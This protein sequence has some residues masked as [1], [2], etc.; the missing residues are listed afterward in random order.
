[1]IS[2]IEELGSRMHKDALEVIRAEAQM[3]VYGG[4]L[5]FREIATVDF[6]LWVSWMMTT[7][8]TMGG[9]HIADFD[10]ESAMGIFEDWVKEGMTPEPPA[11][12]PAPKENV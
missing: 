8:R 9:I 4:K 3:E 6:I 2:L 1:M 7:N 12:T 10:I 11:S 5:N